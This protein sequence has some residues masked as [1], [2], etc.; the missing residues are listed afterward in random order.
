MEENASLTKTDWEKIVG[1]LILAPIFVIIL[2]VI[3]FVADCSSQSNPV[4][5]EQQK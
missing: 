2:E 5:V 1:C 3:A 4:P